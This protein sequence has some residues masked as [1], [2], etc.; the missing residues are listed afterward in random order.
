MLYSC[1]HMAAVD[2]KWLKGLVFLLHCSVYLT[3]I[4]RWSEWMSLIIKC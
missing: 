2:V 4:V 1:N 3:V